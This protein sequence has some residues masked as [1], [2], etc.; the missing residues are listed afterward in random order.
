MFKKIGI[1]KEGES[2]KANYEL[3]SLLNESS[4]DDEKNNDDEDSE[5]EEEFDE[6]NDTID[7]NM[8]DDSPGQLLMPEEE[9]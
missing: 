8:F 4:S 6:T 5:D 7:L 3:Q 9:K 2:N 1:T